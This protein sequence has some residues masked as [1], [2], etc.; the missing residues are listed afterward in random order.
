MVHQIPNT[1]EKPRQSRDLVAK[2]T[3][4]NVVSSITNKYICD[5]IIT[6]VFIKY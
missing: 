3:R 1:K 2:T 5:R 4:K 6:R